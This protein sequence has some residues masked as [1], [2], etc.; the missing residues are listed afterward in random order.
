MVQD[1]KLKS[2]LSS[3]PSNVLEDLPRVVKFKLGMTPI[4]NPPTNN[5]INLVSNTSGVLN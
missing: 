3:V 1:E 4:D 2:A 5:P